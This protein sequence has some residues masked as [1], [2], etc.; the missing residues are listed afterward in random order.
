MYKRIFKNQTKLSG[1]V[2]FY[3]IGAFSKNPSAFIDKRLFDEYIGKYLFSKKGDI[4]A[5]ASSTVGR[6][7][8]CYGES[9]Y[10]QDSSIIWLQHNE[11]LILNTFLKYVYSRTNWIAES[12]S[13]TMSR[14][15]SS[16]FLAMRVDLLDIKEQQK[17]AAFL[18][19][20]DEKITLTCQ[21]L[22]KTKQFKK[23]LLQG[24][25]V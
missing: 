20:L 6:L 15:N 16:N 7:V 25:F 14:L 1:D 18:F 3:V 8:V 11:G 21:Q 17:I 9:A 2:P 23:G 4:L 5:S 12:K 13:S 10:F 24:M 19:A 22:D